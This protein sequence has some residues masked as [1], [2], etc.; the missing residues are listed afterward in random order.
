M[1]RS[2]IL[3]VLGSEE[4][5]VNLFSI[6]KQCAAKCDNVQNSLKSILKNK[7]Q[8]CKHAFAQFKIMLAAGL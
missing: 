7:T 1:I 5:K 2:W 6:Y 4:F 8:K 3:L